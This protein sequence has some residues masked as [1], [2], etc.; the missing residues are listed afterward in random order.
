MAS[1]YRINAAF[2]ERT[3]TIVRRVAAVQNVSMSAVVRDLVASMAP[4]LDQVAKLGEAMQSAVEDQKCAI[5][6]AIAEVD[7][8]YAERLLA[9]VDVV[10][11]AMEALAEA[12]PRPPLGNT[13]VR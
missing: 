8:E 11:E 5:R 9:A 4:G 13:G 3:Y 1:K 10:N 2:D 7:R 12:S 6:T